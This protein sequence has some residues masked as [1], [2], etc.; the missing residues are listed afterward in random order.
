M[1]EKLDKAF[2]LEK[3]L[4]EQYAINDNAKS[5]NFISFLV[6]ILVIFYSYGIVYIHTLSCSSYV[7][8]IGVNLE[9]SVCKDILCCLTAAM[10]LLLLFLSILVIVLGYSSRRDHV[11]IE[12]IRK[13]EF[14]SKYKNYFPEDVF[15]SSNKKWY[16]F[17]PDYYLVFY[18]AF[19]V[20]NVCII[21]LTGITANACNWTFILTLIPEIASVLLSIIIYSLYHQKYIE[22]QKKFNKINE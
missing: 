17:L 11:V 9:E 18:W 7:T 5:A 20:I 4:H 21:T 1:C 3:H 13:K 14:E 19:L 6:S 22:F 15:S 8:L 12:N 10:S 16:N 2:E